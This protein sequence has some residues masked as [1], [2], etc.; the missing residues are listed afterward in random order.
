MC[1]EKPVRATNC[2]T[3]LNSKAPHGR[4]E[5]MCNR[6]FPTLGVTFLWL[7][8][9][10]SALHA[11]GGPENL[12]VVINPSSEDSK[13]IGN[14]YVELRKVP[15]SNI[16]EIPWDPKEPIAQVD[17]FR[18]K[19]LGPILTAI[20]NR[21][22]T[23]QIDCIAYS[24]DFP[25]QIQ[26]HKDAK[27]SWGDV[28]PPRHLGRVASLTGATFLYEP[29]MAKEAKEYLNLG[30]NRYSFA[31]LVD[32]K[33]LPSRGFKNQFQ[34][35]PR[36]NLVPE[37]GRRY[38]MSVM[39]GVTYGKGNTVEEIKSY[40]SKAA[41]ADGTKP[42][43]TIYFG[44]DNGIRAKTRQ[45]QFEAAV[46][47][48][49]LIGVKA[50]IFKGYLPKEKGDVQGLMVGTPAFDW[51]KSQSTILPGAICDH[52]T[53][54]G[55]VMS[56]KHSQTRLSEYLR[57]GAAAA[58]G[59]VVEPFAI[60]AKFPNAAMHVHYARGCTLAESFYQSVAGP[61]QLLIVG[62]PL[63][64]P[65]ANIPKIIAAG[66]P[67]DGQAKGTL[68]INAMAT[69]IDRANHFELYV[70]SVRTH[71]NREGKFEIDTTKLKNGPHEIRIIAIEASPILSQGHLIKQMEISN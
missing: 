44:E 32:W 61:Y 59:T 17:I 33:R 34:F 1:I 37:N 66:L 4:L 46:A 10:V 49:N 16:V 47:Q 8:T 5:A 12:L 53:S 41:Q 57:H 20:T 58:S 3:K 43:G 48:L 51:S 68:N 2:F 14:F 55:G 56:E 71:I 36:G 13:E 24:C 62:D 23:K 63:C 28:S 69:G 39:L 27:N 40:L 11:G 35:D 6:L 29:V 22:L 25:W 19:I 54:F 30:S 9:S 67:K 18:E 70:D 42:K 7:T 45:N 65:W 38:L 26:C 50:E 60:A 31:S 64:R 15:D 21:G 52:L